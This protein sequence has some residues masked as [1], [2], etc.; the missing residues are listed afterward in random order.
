MKG[1]TPINISEV[2]P[3]LRLVQ[4]VLDDWSVALYHPNVLI[5]PPIV[6]GDSEERSG[7]LLGYDDGRRVQGMRGERLME[8]ETVSWVAMIALMK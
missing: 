6:N 2:L 7:G 8:G 4:L 5:D 1:F 3:V